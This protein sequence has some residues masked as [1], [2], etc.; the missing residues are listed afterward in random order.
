MLR[1]ATLLSSSLIVIGSAAAQDSP[2]C[3]SIDGRVCADS[4]RASIEQIAG[5]VFVSGAGGFSPAVIGTN[6]GP[7]Q[8][9]LTR[10]GAAQVRLSSA[11]L[12]AV[13]ANSLW[14]ISQSDNLICVFR[15][16]STPPSGLTQTGLTFPIVGGA[17]VGVGLVGGVAAL[18]ASDG[19]KPLSP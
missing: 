9:I 11:C 7:G 3:R 4:G 18:A 10:K 1:F 19:K 15:Q 13:P 14:R 6:L 8:A 17:L 5:E 2:V 12:A 16:P